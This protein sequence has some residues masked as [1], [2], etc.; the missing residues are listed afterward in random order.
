MPK[1]VSVLIEKPISLTKAKTPTSDTGIVAVGMIVLRQSCR[2][3]NMTM[4]TSTIASN[5]VLT[6]SR[7]ESFT[8][9]AVSNEIWYCMPGG[10]DRLSRSSSATQL[11]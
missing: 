2:N 10:N 3:R 4:M 5:S 6:T 8:T 11:L 1:S 9:V 7:I